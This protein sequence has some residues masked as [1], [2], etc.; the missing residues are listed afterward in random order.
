MFNIKIESKPLVYGYSNARAHAM[1]SKLLTS[2]QLLELIQM[3]STNT[4]AEALNRTEYKEEILQL[5]LNYKGEQLIDFALSENFAKFCKKLYKITPNKDKKIIFGLLSRWDSHNIKTV[6]LA[7]KQKKPWNEIRPFL[8]LAG[9]LQLQQL[10]KLYAAA[11][12]AEFYSL[13]RL[14]EF[15]SGFINSKIPLLTKPVRDAFKTMDSDSFI[16]DMLLLSLDFYQYQIL[17]K[18]VQEHK[19]DKQLAQFLSSFTDEKN[20]EIVL[21]LSKENLS[22]EKLRSYLL[23]GGKIQP[24]R[25]LKAAAKKEPFAILTFL[26]DAL[27]L[28]GVIEEF[29]KT[30]KLSE[31][32]KLV[33]IEFSKKRLKL[34]RGANLSV[35][36]LVAALFFKEQEVENI[37]KILRGKQY[38]FSEDELKRLILFY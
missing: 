22:D 16:F 9:T 23:P 4:I 6:I 5:S 29:K 10:E 32:E 26:A 1:F 28:K 8:V 14:T 13:F 18:I 24:S 35:A 20:L 31:I 30:K 37:R 33:S 21:R 38:G 27:P 36:V 34:F 3:P 17:S 11:D 25:W 12:S 2:Q 7:R 19:N 15:G